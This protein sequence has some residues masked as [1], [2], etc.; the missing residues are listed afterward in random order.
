MMNRIFFLAL[1]LLVTSFN[2]FAY[3]IEMESKHSNTHIST[4]YSFNP[5]MI[6]SFGKTPMGGE[7]GV[8]VHVEGN[9]MLTPR[10]DAV[11]YPTVG[12]IIKQDKKL[13][14]QMDE[15]SEL[16]LLAKKG[17]LGS[18]VAVEGVEIES[19]LV[20]RGSCYHAQV[21]IHID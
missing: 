11:F 17:F 13:F 5:V 18:W 6:E 3:S 16:V 9:G 2:V 15:A 14:Y 20:I 4:A 7:Y 8:I 10:Y 21:V 1:V 12:K 19:E